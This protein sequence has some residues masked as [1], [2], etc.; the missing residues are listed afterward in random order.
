MEEETKVPSY[1]D[2]AASGNKIYTWIRGYD[3]RL[4]TRKTPISKYSYL[5]I[6]NNSEEEIYKNIYGVPM[7]RVDFKTPYNMRQYAE[8]HSDVHES[9]VD[10]NYK[11]L[12][13]NFYDSDLSSPYNLLY[14]DIEVDFDLEDGY[15][16]PTPDNP[17][18]EINAISTFDCYLNRYI[19]YVPN[20]LKGK[21]ELSDTRDGYP[22]E[23]VWCSSER[24]MLQQFKAGIEHIDIMTS[25]NGESYDIPYIMERV[26]E[27][28]GLE[29]AKT[30]LCRNDI[31]AYK[32]TFINKNGQEVSTWNI[33]G[34][35]HLDMMEIYKKFK[36]GEKRSF[37]L[38]NIAQ[39]E[40]GEGKVH[41]E[42]NLGS[43]YRENPEKFFDYSLHD[44][45][46]LKMLN[47]KTNII[48]LAVLL[49]RGACSRISDVTGSVKLIDQDFIKFCRRYNIVVPDAKFE[50][51]NAKYD[52]AVV[53][54]SVEGRHEWVIAIDVA[55][56]Y[57]HAIILLGL[58]PET[59]IFQCLNGYDDFVH[60]TTKNDQHGKIKI[61]NVKTEEVFEILPSEMNGIIKE[62]GYTISG[63]GTIFDGSMG[64][65][66]TYMREGFAL[67]KKYKK[68]MEQ[69]Q[70]SGDKDSERMYDLYQNVFKLKIN[71]FY[72]ITGNDTFRF[73][74]LDI[75]K[76]ITITA[77]VI[78]K[79][80][81]FHGQKAL[82]IIK[83]E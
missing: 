40:L 15:G 66:A 12:I 44:S 62:N 20:H 31:P 43:V 37:S 41:Y 2:C 3:G 52:G 74:I 6:P 61:K 57:P 24:E 47:E 82:N 28:F 7:K 77:Q 73:F 4:T 53:F 1:I 55:S 10:P 59:M 17:F 45:R 76:S 13:D 30:F 35:V 19:M 26:I 71:S 75:A 54:D 11:Y 42:D 21:F 63:N 16:Y 36:P 72:G 25:W 34:R 67:R 9:D 48:N 23:T 18:G 50:N 60:I 14:F 22:V 69:A 8:T 33:Y 65:F 56:M 78:A 51:K 80:Q 68:M 5:F 29:E 79:W 58:S 27:N 38:E 81:T 32:R 46:L 83:G 39:H 49:S 64:L 70:A